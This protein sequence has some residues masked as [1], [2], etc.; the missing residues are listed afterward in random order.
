MDFMSLIYST[1][2]VLIDRSAALIKFKLKLKI[3][4][5]NNYNFFYFDFISHKEEDSMKAPSVLYILTMN[6]SSYKLH[7]TYKLP[8][9]GEI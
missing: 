2:I 5:S 4:R 7:V 9:Y 8:F 1:F 6:Q 3:W